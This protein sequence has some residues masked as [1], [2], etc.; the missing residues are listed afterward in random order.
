M[1]RLTPKPTLKK[2]GSDPKTPQLPQLNLPLP[3]PHLLSTAKNKSPSISG[4]SVRSIR[5]DKRHS[6]DNESATLQLALVELV[7]QKNQLDQKLANN[8][9][10]FK[11]VLIYCKRTIEKQDE[12]IERLDETIGKNEKLFE[13]KIVKERLKAQQE[14]EELKLAVDRLNS[15]NLLM[16]TQL[17]NLEQMDLE[18]KEMRQTIEDLKKELEEKNEKIGKRELKERELIII[19]TEKVRKELEK[20]F[21]EEIIKVKKE[22][23]IQ[24]MAHME[25]NQHLVKK[26]K[27]DLHK[28]LRERDSLL[29]SKRKAEAEVEIMREEAKKSEMEKKRVDKILQNFNDEAEK[30]LKQTEK[31]LADCE[32]LRL[33][34]AQENEEKIMKMNK[35]LDEL[36]IKA[37]QMDVD[38]KKMKD[39]LENETKAR[40]DMSWKLTEQNKRI[41]HLKDF[42]NT[43]LDT[44]NDSYIDV[45]MGENRA[46]I[47]G[48]LSVMVNSIPVLS[49]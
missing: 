40:I 36:K 37:D 2:G 34:D 18:L 11:D 17:S 43:V 31:R 24:N 6:H 45:I 32:D 33:R 5:F 39:Q 27:A 21:E 29:S 19:T 1:S 9:H 35:E 42:L 20:E 48:K 28:A 3:F 47:F 10:S 44:S 7:K 22:M 25:A 15:E 14:M 12:Q 41:T 30:K 16:K 13:E 8:T 49:L 23:R 26:A 4:R 46:A 38:Y